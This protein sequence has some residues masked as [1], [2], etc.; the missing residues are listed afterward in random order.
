MQVVSVDVDIYFCNII[1]LPIAM[2]PSLDMLENKLQ[3]QH[4]HVMRFHKV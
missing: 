3:I 2:A 4:L 1:W